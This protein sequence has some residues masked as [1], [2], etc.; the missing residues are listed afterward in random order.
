[1]A[2]NDALLASLLLGQRQRRDPLEIYQSFGRQQAQAGSSTAPLGSGNALEGIARALQGGLGGLVQGWA[3]GQQEKDDAANTAAF[4]G[5][6]MAATPQ[7]FAE[8]MKGARGSEGNAVLGQ[9]AQSRLGDLIAQ[10]QAGVKLGPLMPPMT[11]GAASPSVVPPAQ[12]PQ[13]GGGGVPQPGYGAA[14]SPGS[15][16]AQAIAGIESSGQPNGGYGAIG[17]QTAQGRAYGKY[18]VLDSNIGPW[19][20]EILGQP[21]TPQQF[22]ASP[23]AQDKVFETKFGQYVTQYGSPQAASR[24]WFAGPGGMNNPNA[25]DVNGMSVAQYEKKF[26]GAL[27]AQG[28]DSTPLNQPGPPTAMSSPAGDQLRQRAQAAQQAG[29]NVTALKYAQEAAQEDAKWA[30]KVGEKNVDQV[31]ADANYARA[32]ADEEARHQRGLQDKKDNPTYTQ[33]QNLSHTYATRLNNAIPQLEEIVR[34]GDIPSNTQRAAANSP[35]VPE[36]VISE[37]AKE[38]RR[39]VKDILSATLRRESG[40]SIADSEY[41]SE[42]QKF[43]PLATDPPEVAANKIAALKQA[44]RSIAEGTGRPIGSYSFF[45]NAPA[46]GTP[47]SQTGGAPPPPP[48]FRPL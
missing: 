20:Q 23:E 35:Y 27:P 24:A 45:G 10:Q 46:A 31:A 2:G 28:S 13:G 41:V 11:A 44:A 37:K 17:P 40:A 1:M 9:I 32:K 33:E 48:G 42:A 18:Q 39:V 26:N 43:I 4:R 5:A 30:T 36:G 25:T 21:M 29:D 3:L 6:A 19:T 7:E 16:N 12:L 14:T 47:A 38:Y 34:R 22:L 15:V 8:A